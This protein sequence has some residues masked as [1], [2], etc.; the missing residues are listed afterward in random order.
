[1][2]I[3]HEFHKHTEKLAS[4]QEEGEEG[5]GRESSSESVGTTCC[6]SSKEWPW[7]SLEGLRVKVE[8]LAEPNR[9]SLTYNFE[10]WNLIKLAMMP[11]WINAHLFSIG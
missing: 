4:Q 9:I 8:P 5:V 10:L 7:S 2:T 6:V 1:M 11:D 3:L